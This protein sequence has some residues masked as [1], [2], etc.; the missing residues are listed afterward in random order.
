MCFAEPTVSGCPFFDEWSG[1]LEN[2]R[3]EWRSCRS[4]Q[5]CSTPSHCGQKNQITLEE[6]QQKVI[7]GESHARVRSRTFKS[8][9]GPVTTP[10]VRQIHL[11]RSRN[12]SIHLKVSK[13]RTNANVV[14]GY[15]AFNIME[16]L[17]VRKEVDFDRYT[18]IGRKAHPEILTCF[19]TF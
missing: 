18:S 2:G 15:G 9:T 8:V 4:V 14:Y 13:S 19:T 17:T 12:F 1:G 6:P 5:D 3:Q 16:V 11:L 10:T 7:L